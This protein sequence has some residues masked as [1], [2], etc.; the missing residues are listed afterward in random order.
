[1][2][3]H[4]EATVKNAAEKNAAAGVRRKPVV[5]KVSSYIFKHRLDRFGIPASGDPPYFIY[6]LYPT[7]F[8]LLPSAINTTR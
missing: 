1:M 5:M 2:Q 4:K 3:A 8:I 7:T 6:T